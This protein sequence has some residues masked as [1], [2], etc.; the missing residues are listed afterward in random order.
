MF[1]LTGLSSCFGFTVEYLLVTGTSSHE[2]TY[3]SSE[4]IDCMIY[5]TATHTT[6]N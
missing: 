5:D 2:Y 4:N 1:L 3:I 6:H